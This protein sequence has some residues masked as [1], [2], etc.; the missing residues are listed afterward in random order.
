MERSYCK[1][2][3][4][5]FELADKAK[6]TEPQKNILEHLR[7]DDRIL[8]INPHHMSGGEWTWEK[9]GCAGKVYKAFWNLIYNVL[10]KNGYQDNVKFLDFIN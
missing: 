9:A 4:E 3:K 1:S 8:I 5:F 10:Y 7:S 6:L 2:R